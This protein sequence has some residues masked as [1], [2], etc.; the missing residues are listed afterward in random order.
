MA[1][2]TQI[3]NMLI[4]PPHTPDQTRFILFHSSFIGAYFPLILIQQILFRQE[5]VSPFFKI[6]SLG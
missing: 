3:L 6:G 1:V 2:G 5:T 4:H